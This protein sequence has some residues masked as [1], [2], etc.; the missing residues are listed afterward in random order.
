M[1]RR[2]DNLC[3]WQRCLTPLAVS[4]NLHMDPNPS[5]GNSIGSALWFLSEVAFK[6]IPGAVMAVSGTAAPV[7]GGEPVSPLAAPIT[8]P[9]SAPEVVQ[10][11]QLASAP[12]EY[13]QMFQ[14]WS[15]FVAFSLLVTLCLGALI[16]YCAIRVFQIR[17]IERRR[18]YQTRRTVAAQDI[19]KSQLR[20]NRIREEA[21]SDSEQSWRL[22]ILEAD[23]MLNELLD[24][25]GYKGETMADKMRGVDRANFNS[26]DLAWEAHKIR[27]KIAHDGSAHQMTARET[28]RVIALYEKVL[29]DARYIE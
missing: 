22:A 19:P 17:Q 16:I 23:I 14:Q 25:M 11:L 29:K 10:Y 1:G 4:Y 9:V 2:A 21:N 13:D 18:F 3:H 8:T 12:G 7:P 6:W 26:I 28:R 27:N 20:W 24:V 15:T 5:P